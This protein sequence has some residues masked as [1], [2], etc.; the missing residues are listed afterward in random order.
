VF[1]SNT[2]VLAVAAGSPI[3]SLADVEKRGTILAVGTA[4]VPVGAYTQK[5]LARLPVFKR[6]TL[7]ADIRDREPDVA[8]IVGKLVEG[9][10]DAGFVYATDVRATGG[11]LRAILLP[12]ALQP[13]VAYAIA[14][15]RGTSHAP[16]AR[17]FIAGLLSGAGR[18]DLQRDGFLPP[19]D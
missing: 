15:V 9:A 13:R 19:P 17:S 11:R 8:G 7:E 16:D 2:L 12:P 14:V 4:S 10:A 5:V 3:K 6:R 18:T 1:T